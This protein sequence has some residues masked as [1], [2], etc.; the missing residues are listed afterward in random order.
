MELEVYF[1]PVELDPAFSGNK[2]HP[3]KYGDFIIPYTE[4]SSFPDLTE[5]DIALIGVTEDRGAVENE[6]CGLAADVIRKYF[7][8][9]FPGNYKVKV[10]D[11]GNLHRGA[12]VED[13]FFVLTNVLETLL[14]NKV[15]PV[16]MG[17]S[18]DNTVAMYRAYQNLN[19]IVN[20]T[21]IDRL[22][23]MGDTEDTL[24]SQSYLS[25]II[26]HKPNYLFNFSNV[27]YQTH[28][29]DPAAI[30]LMKQLFFDSCRLG[31]AQTDLNRVEPMIRNADIVS[32][33]I[34]ALRQSDAPGNGN[35]TPN[36]FYGEDACQMARFAGLS[37]KLSSIGFFEINPVFDRNDQTAQLLAQMIW[38]LIDGFY[39][40][41][42]Q[43]P[44]SDPEAFTRYSVQLSGFD[45][46]IVFFRNKLTE[47]WWM[48]VQCS[49]N[50]RERYK[51]HYIVPCT[52]NDY[53][54]ACNDEIPDRWWQA[55]QKLM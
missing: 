42:V 7:Y 50:I 4:D 30:E 22:F 6:G 8:S 55:Y 53:N 15:L 29:V 5:A 44:A 41:I 1:K 49:D 11:L 12:T 18:Q 48:E 2:E 14:R 20:I 37:D 38:Y 25:K 39:N 43:R 28:Y 32:F 19:H 21:A 13:S 40:R 16:L 34:S 45:D 47:R 33:D 31:L 10:V 23:D 17:G 26:L 27:G 35:A 54:D 24:N 51:S 52:Q 9:L 36:G 3:K 46:G